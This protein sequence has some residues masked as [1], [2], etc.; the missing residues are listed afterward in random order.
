MLIGLH[1]SEKEHFKKAKTFPNYAL[2]KISAYYKAKGDTV[3]WWQ[4]DKVYDMVYSSKI[5]DFTKENE[6]LPPN[7]IKGG[8]GYNIEKKLPKEIDD[9]YPDYSIYPDCDYA[10]GYITRG[11]P[12]KCPWCYVPRKEGNI[13][14][15]RKWEEI[16]RFDTKKLILMDN[17]ILAS[18][19]GISEL[20]R[21]V[22]SAIRIDLNQGM[23]VRLVTE[24]VA[25]ILASLNWIKYIRFSCDTISQIKSIDRVAY[26]LGERGIKPYRLFIYVLVR[27]DLDE[28]DYRVQQLK[29][30]KGIHLYAQAERNEG[31]GIRPNKAQLEFTNRY[32]YGNL[33]RK[34]TW[35]EYLSKRPWVR[36]RLEEAE[37]RVQNA[38]TSD[39]GK[40]V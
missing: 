23:D 14:P 25:D 17:N 34:E 7:T 20:K 10:I 3:E 12:R 4:Q 27:K 22:G 6:N 11:C 40:M 31:L 21:M 30:H 28:A 39:N 36:Q 5:F 15:Y 24:E 33:Y 35:K 1:D 13:A 19:Y 26:M 16:V 29:K 18:K 9:M 2:M 38:D 37:R 32:I 8:T